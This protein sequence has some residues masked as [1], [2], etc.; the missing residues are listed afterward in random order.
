MLGKSSKSTPASAQRSIASWRSPSNAGWYKWVCVS[1]HFILPAK[2]VG[3][4][5]FD[6]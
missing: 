2:I 6:A 4:A 1:I 3:G 5:T